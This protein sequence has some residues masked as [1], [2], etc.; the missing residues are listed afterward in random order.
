MINHK[1]ESRK[2]WKEQNRIEGK[3]I[4]ILWGPKLKGSYSV[5]FN[6]EQTWRWDR[7][8]LVRVDHIVP[9]WT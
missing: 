7:G 6:F 1:T 4:L 8:G 9:K 2:N 5:E 3:T